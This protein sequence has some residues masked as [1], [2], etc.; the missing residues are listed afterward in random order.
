MLRRLMR[1]GILHLGFTPQTVLSRTRRGS[2]PS[3]CTTVSNAF[4]PMLPGLFDGHCRADD[5]P[6]GNF[7]FQ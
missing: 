5:P 7:F 4:A 2:F 3:A 6:A 1:S